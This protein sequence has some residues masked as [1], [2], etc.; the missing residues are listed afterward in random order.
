VG[1]GENGVGG[2]GGW[3]W[4]GVLV[5]GGGGAYRCVWGWGCL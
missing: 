3:M 5:C 2:L 1:G 4:E